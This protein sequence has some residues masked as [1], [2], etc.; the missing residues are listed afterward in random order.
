MQG[1]RVQSLVGK[2]YPTCCNNN[3]RKTQNSSLWLGE[4][5]LLTSASKRLL[6]T[7][8]SPWISMLDPCNR[9]ATRVFRAAVTNHYCPK[10]ET[11]SCPSKGRRVLCDASCPWNTMQSE[12]EP[13]TT[14]LNTCST[15][16]QHWR[17]QVQ[18]RYAT[19]FHLYQEQPQVT[20]IVAHVMGLPKQTLPT[21]Q[22]WGLI[23]QA[24]SFCDKWSND[25][26]GIYNLGT[27]LCV[28]L[29]NFYLFAMWQAGS[30][31]QAVGWNPCI[32][33]MES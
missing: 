21:M 30:S 11:T 13:E 19:W 12:K 17:S 23:T 24:Y 16:T 1:A 32:R 5:K 20:Y 9:H 4:Y 3:S 14:S 10:L 26:L 27:L 18:K 33:S 22:A 6:S 8:Q 28:L 29:H 31:S 15:P 7:Q 2:L 25:N